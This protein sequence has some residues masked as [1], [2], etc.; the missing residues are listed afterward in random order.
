MR[1]ACPCGGGERIQ[2]HH[3]FWLISK[4]WRDSLM[5]YLTAAFERSDSVEEF[6]R[7]AYGLFRLH[8]PPVPDIMECPTCGRLFIHAIGEDNQY[9]FV[10]LFRRDEQSPLIQNLAA[11]FPE[12]DPAQQIYNRPE[13]AEPVRYAQ[14]DDNGI[15]HWTEVRPRW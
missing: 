4:T 12:P 10:A 11:I 5:E 7:R 1:V 13:P 2:E 8:R 9:R 14:W 3:E 15:P 6:R